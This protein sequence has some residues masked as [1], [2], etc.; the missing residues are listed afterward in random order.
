MAN[1]YDILKNVC[2][3]AHEE[4]PSSFLT[5]ASPYSEIKQYINNIIEEVCSKFYWT[6]RE[7]T[8]T[9]QT[10][11]GQ[12]EYDLPPGI[13]SSGIIENGVRIEGT[14][15]PLYFMIHSDLDSIAQTSGKP[16]RY[17]V[18]ADKLILDP[19]PNAAYSL[20]IKYLTVNFAFNADKTVE[21][22]NLE[23]EDDIPIIPDRFLKVIEWGAYSLYRQNFKPD[24]KY[25]LAR[26][27]YLEFLLDMQKH[28]NYSGDASPSILINQTL[29]PKQQMLRDFFRQ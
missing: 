12:R 14:S 4:K 3:L 10:V 29:N 2:I 21:K 19:A 16:Y 9:L 23:L 22:P 20:I 8:F 27:K 11:A 18:Y 15:Q 28:D 26:D 1:F 6:F 5:S 7:R 25:K 24:N 17:S 13:V